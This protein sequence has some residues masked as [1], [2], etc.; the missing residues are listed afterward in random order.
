MGTSPRSQVGNPNLHETSP[1]YAALPP[2]NENDPDEVR[3][4]RIE[5][6]EQRRIALTAR[7]I[8]IP[9]NGLDRRH[10]PYVVAP[11][12]RR[13]SVHHARLLPPREEWCL[14]VDERNEADGQHRLDAG[15]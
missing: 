15:E 2:S 9:P 3:V 12:A 14:L 1:Q 4:I 11:P 10:Q 5:Q 13:L 6:I 8:A 7:L